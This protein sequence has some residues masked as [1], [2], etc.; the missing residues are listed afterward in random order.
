MHILPTDLQIM[1]RVLSMQ[2]EFL[3]SQADGLLDHVARHS[4]PPVIAQDRAGPGAGFDAVRGGIAKAHLSQ[5][6][7]NVFPD[8]GYACVLEW[9]ELASRFPGSYRF[10]FR[11]QWR[12]PLG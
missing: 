10:L 8:G 2:Y 12:R 5:N 9:F 3:F 4:Q 7:E 1:R 6:S 11:G